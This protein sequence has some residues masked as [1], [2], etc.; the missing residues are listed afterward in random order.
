MKEVYKDIP[1]YEGLYQV[2]NLGNVFN[3]AKN[4][5]CP[6]QKQSAGY[7]QV[8]LKINNL[9]Y[10]LVHRLVAKAFIPNP[11]SKKTV[12]HINLDKNDNRIENLEWAT[13]KEQI[14]HVMDLGWFNEKPISQ[15][16]LSWIFIKHWRS[17]TKASSWLWITKP[18][19]SQAL[20]WKSKT[21]WWFIWKYAN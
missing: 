14:Q 5:F 20:K 9:K 2:S 6:I 12:N 3:V 7:N 4:K 13:Q 11:E 18:A 8:C 16:S 21:S 1:W 19:I 17:I 15:F 10:M